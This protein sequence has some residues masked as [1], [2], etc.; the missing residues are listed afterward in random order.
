MVYYKLR[1]VLQSAMD[2]L[3]IATA[4]TKCDDYYK[5]RQYTESEHISL[6]EREYNICNMVSVNVLLARHHIWICKNKIASSN[7]QDFLQYLK[8]TYLLELK[9]GD[10]PSKK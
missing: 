9:P 4:I 8:P 5:L 6:V 2:L 3:Q 7:I 10:S 1:Q